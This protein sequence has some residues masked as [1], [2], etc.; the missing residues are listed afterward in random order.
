MREGQENAEAAGHVFRPPLDSA[1]E[2]H[3]APVQ[4]PM[5]PA[6]TMAIQRSAGNAAVSRVMG[7]SAG[8]GPRIPWAAPGTASKRNQE[9]S[10]I[11]RG[12]SPPKQQQRTAKDQQAT[13]TTRS[14]RAGTAVKGGEKS[15]EAEEIGNPTLTFTSRYDGAATQSLGGN[16]EIGF[17]QMATLRRANGMTTPAGDA[18][19][20]WQEVTDENH[21]ITPDAVN[22]R[23]KRSKRQWAVDGPFR[24]PYNT[25]DGNIVNAADHISFDDSP[26]F[27][28]GMRM[29]NGYWLSDYEV[30]F[31]WK[32]RRK[33]GGRFTKAEPFWTSD[34]MVH[35]VQSEF[36]PDHPE[37]SA[38]V[39][40]TAAGN[41]TW[42]VDLPN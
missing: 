12:E 28:G 34:E 38:P 32:V 36:D 21:Q 29:S 18:Y 22:Y 14:G 39:N 41:R 6:R 5:T 23:P 11:E 26:G 2:H 13:R 37:A 10:G 35:R 40:A 42:N 16:A 31:R 27:S 24:P 20:F 9:A 3:V 15:G 25:E 19:D 7:E 33:L 4:G 1:R 30:R 17:Q 8:A